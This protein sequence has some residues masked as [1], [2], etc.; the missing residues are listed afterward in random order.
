MD[1]RQVRRERDVD[2]HLAARHMALGQ[3]DRFAAARRARTSLHLQPDRPHEIEDLED[4][5]VGHLRF[6][7]DVAEDRLRVGEST[8]RPLEHAR[9]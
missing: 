6:V 2:R 7:D 9:P 1:R 8:K 3:R 5:G 4:D